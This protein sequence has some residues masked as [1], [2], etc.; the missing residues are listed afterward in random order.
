MA[1]KPSSSGISRSMR[2]TS[3]VWVLTFRN[4]S[5]PSRAV[6][7][8]RNSPEDSRTSVSSRRKKGLSSTTSTRPGSELLDTMR[9]RDDFDLP[10]A[11]RKADGS[12]EIPAYR[13]SNQRHTVIL[14]YLSCSDEIPLTHVDG[15]GRSQRG[16]HA[17]AASQ[18]SRDPRQLSA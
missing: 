2:M 17:R 12:S 5:M 11:H 13:L 3:G 9:D 10:V 6:A 4:A 7:T 14:Q 15:P 16:E 8:T 1:P 18:P